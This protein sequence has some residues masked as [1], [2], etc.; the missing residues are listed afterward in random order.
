MAR[1]DCLRSSQRV[2]GLPKQSSGESARNADLRSV[3][4]GPTGWR[5]AQIVQ[6]CTSAE[7]GW[8]RGF[9][10]R[11][12][13]VVLAGLGHVVIHA[14]VAGSSG[15]DRARA[16]RVRQGP[17]ARSPHWGLSLRWAVSTMRRCMVVSIGAVVPVRRGSLL[18]ILCGS[19][20]A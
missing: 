10:L 12:V 5:R 3:E 6:I 19:S 8:G 13:R 1:S 17:A 9:G 4:E 14:E 15:G 2:S 7:S 11:R 20:D 18:V 16:R